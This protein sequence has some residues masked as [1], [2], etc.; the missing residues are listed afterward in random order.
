MQ[1][2]IDQ[3]SAYLSQSMYTAVKTTGFSEPVIKRFAKE[4]N[5]YFK[6]AFRSLN[7]ID[8]HIIIEIKEKYSSGDYD[9]IQ[10]SVEYNIGPSIINKILKDISRPVKFKDDSFEQYKKL[11][12]RLTTV[13]K[14]IFNIHAPPG[15]H[16]DHRYSLHDGYR[17]GVPA[18]LISS[19]ENLQILSA[20]D[21]LKKGSSS[22]ITKDELYTLL[23]I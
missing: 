8:R 15:S 16:V 20:M 2:S 22:S 5:I 1:F 9:K 10:L 3:V 13:V 18:Y 11:V 17:H 19:K 23:K 21:N 6:K 7:D 4:H 14:N 12:R